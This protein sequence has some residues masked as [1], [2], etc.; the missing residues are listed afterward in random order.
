[1]HENIWKYVGS[2]QAKEH[3]KQMSRIC[4]TERVWGLRAQPLATHLCNSVSNIAIIY[5][6]LYLQFLST[7][8]K[9]TWMILEITFAVLVVI[10][11]I[12]NNWDN[13][14]IFQ[15]SGIVSSQMHVKYN[16]CCSRS[17]KNSRILHE[18]WCCHFDLWGISAW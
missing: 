14:S 13:D 17:T 8:K 5:L 1:M 2:N 4:P 9:S 6:I 3:V 15:W 12:I 11:A 16:L 10:I 7:R 18:V